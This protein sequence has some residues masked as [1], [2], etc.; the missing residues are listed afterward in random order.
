MDNIPKETR[1]RGPYK[2]FLDDLENP[3]LPLLE[4]AP[5]KG[6]KGD[7]GEKGDQGQPGLDGKGGKDGKHGTAGLNGKNGKNGIDGEDG[8]NG[9]NGLN[10][11]DGKDGSPDKPGEIRDKLQTLK[12]DERLDVSAIKGIGARESKLSDTLVN[13]AIGIVDQR[14]S[15]LINK[16]SNLQASKLDVGADIRSL[17]VWDSTNVKYWGAKGDGVT[18]DSAAIQAAMD[19]AKLP[20]ETSN[21]SSVR[22]GHV[23]FP[24][25]KY[26]ITAAINMYPGMMVTGESQ[27]STHIVPEHNGDSF[28]GETPDGSSSTMLRSYTFKDITIQQKLGVTPTAGAAIRIRPQT[29]TGT[30]SPVSV[31]S[32]LHI[33]NVYI[34][35]TYNGVHATAIQGGYIQGLQT[36]YCRGNGNWFDA[37]QTVLHIDGSVSS[38]N[39]QGVT[40]NGWKFEGP[41]YIE[42]SGCGADSNSGYGWW[43]ENSIEQSCYANT[44]NVGSEEN[45]LGGVYLKNQNSTVV[46]ALV[47]IAQGVTTQNGIVVQGQASRVKLLNCS[48]PTVSTCLGYAL[49]VID[50]PVDGSAGV[51][52]TA[53]FLGNLNAGLNIVGNFQA[54]GITQN[55]SPINFEGYQSGN[56]HGY[57]L[58]T[59]PDYPFDFTNRTF[60][61][62]TAGFELARFN[63]ATNNN[64]GSAK[65]AVTPDSGGSLFELEQNS[66]GGGPYNY[67]TTFSDSIIRNNY[68]ATAGQFGSIRFVTGNSIAMTIA[69]G[70][71]RGNVGIGT[72]SPTQKLQVVGTTKT[73]ELWDISNVKYWGAIGN[74]STDDTAAI[75]ACINA[76]N[77]LTGSGVVYFPAGNYKITSSLVITTL[78]YEHTLLIRGQSRGLVTISNYAAVGFACA[79]ADFIM[80]NLSISNIGAFI[81]MT[82][83]YV[84][85]TSFRNISFYNGTAGV[86]V[87]DA[88]TGDTNVL[89]FDNCS[90]FNSVT[91]F[92]SVLAINACL[93][94]MCNFTSN[95]ANSVGIIL[96]GSSNTM[97]QCTF[98]GL[99]R[100][101]VSTGAIGNANTIQGCYFEAITDSMILSSN[102]ITVTQCYMYTYTSGPVITKTGTGL[103]TWTQNNVSPGTGT[104]AYGQNYILMPLTGTHINVVKDTNAAIQLSTS[105]A[106]SG[107]RNWATAT[108]HTSFGDYA[109]LQSTALGGDPVTAG[110]TRFY[111]DQTGNV[112]IGTSA[113]LGKLQITGDVSALSTTGVYGQLEITGSTNSAKRLSLGFNTTTNKAFIQSLINADNYYDLLLNPNGGNVG[114]GV[115]SSTAALHLKAGT[116]NTA[117]LKLTTGTALITPEDGAIEYHSSHIYATI[118]ATRYQLDQ[119]SGGGTVN[120][121]LSISFGAGT[122]LSTMVDLSNGTAGYT[123]NNAPASGYSEAITNTAINA[124]VIVQHNGANGSYNIFARTVKLTF[125]LEL[126]NVTGTGSHYCI[127]GGNGTP[128]AAGVTVQNHI[129]IIHKVVAGVETTYASCGNGTAQTLTAITTHTGRVIY[130]IVFTPGVNIKYYING[131][132]AATI[133]TNLPASAPSY[134]AVWGCKNGAADTTARTIRSYGC[135]AL[136]DSV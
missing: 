124:A 91:G 72:T 12:K 36:Y 47:I 38:A 40:G 95:A 75:Q 9:E 13:R 118:G 7:K 82:L 73:T 5:P 46:T 122:T 56:K 55:N 26:R 58:I 107:A 80:E 22:S 127:A 50:G 76:N 27:E 93:F 103:L 48:I 42:V 57:G 84:V 39:G 121:S 59:P 62:G 6:D 86:K 100:G 133:T 128:D 63:R 77:S 61:N 29:I 126:A 106:N 119:Q 90:F 115:T 51:T 35:G 41:S 23:F 79:S 1:L 45:T 28:Y 134:Y 30:G 131:T 98:Q 31:A 66:G 49:K 104:P 11:K 17:N 24:K 120:P 125:H 69:N 99:Y 85:S 114:I 71:L 19:Y 89:L 4:E 83:K 8:L 123:Y 43:V 44:L 37:Y 129:G 81:C 130:G 96:N 67:S 33:D 18:D 15:F 3:P 94:E 25:G 135:T 70:T 113:P 108:S 101:I 102:E 92:D 32:R 105:S 20:Y 117:P 97:S 16:V 112:G 111:I 78:P 74:G 60:A 21:V 116:A 68:T 87:I 136:F 2:R 109:L 88:S 64:L 54:D 110:V 132:L 34:Y 14:T 53:G 10:G 65:I 52:V